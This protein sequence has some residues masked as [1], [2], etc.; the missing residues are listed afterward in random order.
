MAPGE[1]LPRRIGEQVPSGV[2]WRHPPDALDERR[3]NRVTDPSTLM[4]RE[5]G[6]VGDVEVP[7]AITDHTPQADGRATALAHVHGEP[8][9]PQRCCPLSRRLG[10]RQGPELDSVQSTTTR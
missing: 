5:H 1:P 8:A 3:E 2:R 6:H 10:L 9:A 4:L 7:A